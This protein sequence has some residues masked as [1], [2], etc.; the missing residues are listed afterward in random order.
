MFSKPAILPLLALIM[1]AMGLTLK[2]DDFKNVLVQP[3]VVFLGVSLQFGLMPLLAWMIATVL[4]LEPML[5]VGLILVGACSGGTASNVMTYLAGGNVALSITMTAVSTMLAVF[6]TPW[7]SWLY[8]ETAI[9]VPIWSMFIS[10]FMLV[11]VPVTAGVLFNHFLHRHIKP[12]QNFCP[13]IAVLAIIFII[14][15]V[16]ALNHE[17][18]AQLSWTLLIAV[19]LH[20]L[21]GLFLSYLLAKRAGYST[22]IARTLAIEVGMQNSG[23]AVALALNFFSPLAALPGALFSVWHNI[24]GSVLAAFWQGQERVNNH[25][26][27]D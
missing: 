18:M 9:D 4:Q 8:I 3:L 11:V 12:V 2:L 17:R 23:L 15:I 24:S 5:T 14:A 6:M 10:I 25:D 13:L 1:F 20:N 26:D 16:V 21:S 27:R 19:M 22:V 7:L